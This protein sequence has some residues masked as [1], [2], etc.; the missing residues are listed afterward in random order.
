M[1][2][3]KGEKAELLF[4]KVVKE[5]ET[6]RTVYY[7]VP[8]TEEVHNVRYNKRQN[9]WTCDCRFFAVTMKPCSHILAATKYMEETNDK[10]N[11][12]TKKEI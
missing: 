6:K 9:E 11:R 10:A 4:G 8:G 1:R 3:K 5:T 2:L 12:R 7:H